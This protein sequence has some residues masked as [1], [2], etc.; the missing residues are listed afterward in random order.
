MNI[1]NTIIKSLK[2]IIS[3][4]FQNNN[5]TQ[6]SVLYRT[7]GSADILEL[8]RK[9]EIFKEKLSFTK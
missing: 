7:S 3:K 9:I 5:Y 4:V 8:G 2:T 6:N 1:F